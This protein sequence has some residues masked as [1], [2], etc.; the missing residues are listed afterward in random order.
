MPPQPKPSSTPNQTPLGAQ[1]TATL[2]RTA[3]NTDL[4]F[5]SDALQET[6]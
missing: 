2:G 6:C 3:L 1:K 5:R 4:N